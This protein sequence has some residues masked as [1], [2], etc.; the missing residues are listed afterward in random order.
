MFQLKYLLDALI[1]NQFL[2][3]TQ[4]GKNY[5]TSGKLPYDFK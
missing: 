3:P 4:I 2:H 5:Y 1:K